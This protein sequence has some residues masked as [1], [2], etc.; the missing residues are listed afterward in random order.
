MC[1]R[2]Q[3]K[4]PKS[5]QSLVL[6]PQKM[7]HNIG[8]HKKLPPFFVHALS[9]SAIFPGD[10]RC[11]K[12]VAYC[13]ISYT[14]YYTHTYVTQTYYFLLRVLLGYILLPK[15]RKICVVLFKILGSKWE[16]KRSSHMSKDFCLSFSLANTFALSTRAYL[17]FSL[18]LST[19]SF[20][21][22]FI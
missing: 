7:S 4:Q 14:Q 2:K 10:I 3:Q 9:H 17:F 6:S 12:L 19:L 16:K 8:T 21:I 22:I 5:W 11:K 18:S 20:I 13:H 15:T 1:R